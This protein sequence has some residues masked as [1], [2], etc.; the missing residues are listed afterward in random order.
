VKIT[1]SQISVTVSQQYTATKVAT[2]SYFSRTTFLLTGSL[3]AWLAVYSFSSV[4]QNPSHTDLNHYTHFRN[5]Y[6]KKNLIWRSNKLRICSFAQTTSF[7]H[8][9]PVHLAI[10]AVKMVQNNRP[11]F[12]PLYKCHGLTQQPAPS[13]T[14]PPARSLPVG[15]GGEWTKSKTRG[16]S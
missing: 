13:T 16:L 4:T 12:Q 8:F 1:F 14:Q 5:K 3:F 2:G 10:F 11:E 15:Q 7:V 9:S 6:Q